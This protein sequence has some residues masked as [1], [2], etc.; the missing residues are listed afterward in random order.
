MKVSLIFTMTSLET[1]VAWDHCPAQTKNVTEPQRR[2]ILRVFIVRPLWSGPQGVWHPHQAPTRLLAPP[3]LSDVFMRVAELNTGLYSLPPAVKITPGSG[4]S[5]PIRQNS[6]ELPSETE[7]VHSDHTS[8]ALGS[9]GSWKQG[10]LQTHPETRLHQAQLGMLREKTASKCTMM[11]FFP[12]AASSHPHLVGCLGPGRY[13]INMAG[14]D[15]RSSVL[16]STLLSTEHPTAFQTL[17]KVSASVSQR[18][19]AQRRFK[20]KLWVQE[21]NFTLLSRAHIKLHVL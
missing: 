16:T 8:S 5:L 21:S 3:L 9:Q 12:E 20:T 18:S 6:K 11:L 19:K 17:Y 1:L 7:S 14:R 15:R 13:A 2:P 10:K 4:S